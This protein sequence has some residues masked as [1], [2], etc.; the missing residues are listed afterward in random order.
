MH[1][2]FD[3]KEDELITRPK[4]IHV[5]MFVYLRIKGTC[6]FRLNTNYFILNY[7]MDLLELLPAFYSVVL[8]LVNFS[9][10]SLPKS[11][12]CLQIKET[13]ILILYANGLS[14]AIYF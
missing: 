12:I 7:F 6:L 3:D 11:R 9:I 4:I 14:L 10:I 8:L 1:L 5:F 13:R 2:C